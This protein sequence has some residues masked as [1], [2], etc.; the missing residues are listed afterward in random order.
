VCEWILHRS[1]FRPDIICY[2]LLID[3]YGRKRELS[4]AESV[5]MVLLETHCVP[6]EDTYALLL[7]AYCNAGQLHRAEGVISEM[8]EN[9][10]PPSMHLNCIP[11][12]C[13]MKILV[14][15]EEK[16]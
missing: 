6:T 11:L 16:N 2:N 7:R 15:Q 14:R 9:G 10:I 8:L 4:K 1:S 12:V 13:Q 3:A 5:Y